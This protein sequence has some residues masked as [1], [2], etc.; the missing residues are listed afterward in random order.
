[1]ND[2]PYSSPQVETFNK[3]EQ[4]DG[5][6]SPPSGMVLAVAIV[7]FILGGLGLLCT[8]Y[9]VLFTVRP[10]VGSSPFAQPGMWFIALVVMCLYGLPSVGFVLTGIGL[11]YRKQWGRILAFVVAGLMGLL[12]L[13]NI[14]IGL[15][16]TNE[17]IPSV[18]TGLI[19]L[20][21]PLMIF[22]VLLQRKYANEFVKVLQEAEEGLHE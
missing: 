2:N 21:Y 18:N 22:I 10:A 19:L 3:A 12:G 11:L 8:G 1:M 5:R 14:G 9:S 17:L 4:V 13:W 15:R 7:N 16:N 6:K 20:L